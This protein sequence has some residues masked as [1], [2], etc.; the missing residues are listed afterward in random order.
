MTFV[1][2]ELTM[3]LYQLISF[4]IPTYTNDK[5]LFNL[6][7]SIK[8][9]GS[10]IIIVD[11]LPTLRKKELTN[12]ELITYLP[13]DKNIGFSR[14][15]NRGVK[16]IKTPYFVILNDDIEIKNAKVF[17]ELLNFATKNNLKAVSP[18]LKTVLG[19]IENI[20]YHILP[21]GKIEL[22][23]NLK[24]YQNYLREN[25]LDGL[26][27]ACLLFEIKS[28]KAVGEF[29]ESL[30]A[31]LEDVELFIRMKIR[32]LKF[33]VNTLLEVTHQHQTTSEKMGNFKEK[34]DLKNW[35]K[36]IVKHPKIFPKNN[37]K[38]YVERLKN[39]SGYL[40]TLV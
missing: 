4:V 31:Y 33:A 17:I 28:F 38:L 9:T 25:K 35:I 22:I 18:I 24:T 30:F 26:T 14:A 29:D 37:L 6:V 11:N 23:K 5:G 2:I 13:Q 40:K 10:K 34:Q 21:E 1:T 32:G 36:I 8:K 3:N 27:A 7:K 39:L 20:G 15:V 12:D 19:N 16:E